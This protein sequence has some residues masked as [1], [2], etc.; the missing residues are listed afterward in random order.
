MHNRPRT[1]R[2]IV[3]HH[4][5]KGMGPRQREFVIDLSRSRRSC[6]WLPQSIRPSPLTG[7]GVFV[8]GYSKI[9]A[10]DLMAGHH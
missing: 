5:R 7:W 6:R 2:L 3:C 10:S 4:L 9:V 1:S 8:G